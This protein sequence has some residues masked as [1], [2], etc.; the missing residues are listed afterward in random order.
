[1]PG[2]LTNALARI[3]GFTGKET[4]NVDTNAPAGQMPES[5]AL[6]LT[7]LSLMLNF[8]SQNLAAGKTMVAGTRYFGSFT[9]GFPTLITGL[10]VLVG[11]VGGTDKWTLE[12]FNSSGILVAT[13]DFATGTT[14]GVAATWQ[15]IPFGTL[16][17][18]LPVQI[19]AGT[20][21]ISLQSNGTTAK[22]AAYNAPVAPDGQINGS[23][24]GVFST[25][26]AINPVP[27]T[28]TANLAPMA[29]PY[30]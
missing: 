17:A 11:G 5:G 19:A 10:Q 21:F 4:L 28:Y 18:P 12:L 26:A 23:Q 20:Y 2:F 16:A 14:A 27:T 3:V 30:V 6:S 1:M 25:Q 7:Q 8:L 22:F 9:I 15:Q 24:V 29:L 13:T